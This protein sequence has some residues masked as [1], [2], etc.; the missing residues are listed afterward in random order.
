LN[1][2]F[3]NIFDPLIL[4]AGVFCNYLTADLAR[5]TAA[6]EER[7]AKNERAADRECVCCTGR[8]ADEWS[9]NCTDQRMT[10]ERSVNS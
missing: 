7:V 1:R 9:V 6:G 8:D 3:S 4:T 2:K 5:K 10:T